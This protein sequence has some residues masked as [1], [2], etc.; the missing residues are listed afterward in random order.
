MDAEMAVVDY[1]NSRDLGATAYYDVPRDRPA[2]LIVV[3]RT[4]GPSG[5]GETGRAML[6]VQCWCARDSG[7]RPEAAR[8]AGA[9]VSALREMPAHVADAT[10]VNVTS[11]Y[12]DTDLESGTPRYQVVCEIYLNS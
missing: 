12:R 11:T 2:K 4:G 3:E 9:V 7:G 1:L 6:S 10:G 8:V 5:E